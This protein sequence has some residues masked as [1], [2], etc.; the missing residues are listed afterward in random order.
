M[1]E[2][3]KKKENNRP[4]IYSE[5]NNILTFHIQL[6]VYTCDNQLLVLNC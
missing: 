5:R 4:T 2:E 3:Q 6:H 1:G